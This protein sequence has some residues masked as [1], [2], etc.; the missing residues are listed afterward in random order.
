MVIKG[1]PE[2]LLLNIS[3]EEQRRA[4]GIVIDEG[5]NE[6]WPAGIEKE[7]LCFCFE[8]CRRENAFAI[9]GSHC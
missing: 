4:P 2:V 3:W 7:S 1:L 6:F 8:T 9:T 5:L